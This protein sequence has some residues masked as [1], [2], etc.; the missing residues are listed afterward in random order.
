MLYNRS[1]ELLNLITRSLYP[2]TNISQFIPR[3]PGNHHSTLFLWNSHSAR[4]QLVYGVFH[5][6]SRC[7]NP[8]LSAPIVLLILLRFFHCI[9]IVYTATCLK[10]ILVPWK[11][12]E[13]IKNIF[14]FS[15]FNTVPAIQWVL[16]KFCLNWDTMFLL[17]N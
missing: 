1:P 17:P 7:S 13:A 11:H 3:H 2:L 8:I 9:L 14:L 10:R 15:A 5:D 12:S 6:I 4:G 16:N